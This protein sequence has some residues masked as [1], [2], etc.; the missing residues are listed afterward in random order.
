[1]ASCECC[2]SEADRRGFGGID[3]PDIYHEVLKE[4]KENEC[5][6]TKDTKEGARLRA[7]QFWQDGKDTRDKK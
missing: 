7:G 2:W 6:C 3:V 1:M 5:E 4:H